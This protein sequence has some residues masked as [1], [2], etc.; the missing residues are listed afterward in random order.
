[1]VSPHKLPQAECHV[2]LALTLITHLRTA[3]LEL[4]YHIQEIATLQVVLEQPTAVMQRM[5]RHNRDLLHLQTSSTC[6]IGLDHNNLPNLQ[7]LRTTSRTD[8][9]TIYR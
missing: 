8:G 4:I 7:T 9:R 5:S 6:H 3:L 1:M 2:N